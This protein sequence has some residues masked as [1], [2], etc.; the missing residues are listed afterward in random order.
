MQG[1]GALLIGSKY[2]GLLFKT[3]Y[4]TVNGCQEIILLHLLLVMAGGYQG[5][6]I[7]YV[8]DIGT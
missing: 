1:N 5:C 7:T 2:L 4:Y 6:F 3:A 8:G